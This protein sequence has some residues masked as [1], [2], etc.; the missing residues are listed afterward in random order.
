[1]T[2]MHSDS[3]LA[4]RL[5]ITHPIIQGPFGGGLS[6]VDLVAAV[7]NSGGLGSYGAHIFNGTEIKELCVRIRTK[8]DR[9]FAINLWVSN[10]DPELSKFTEPQF[11]A[12]RNHY[13]EVYQRFGLEPPEWG[14][15]H[16]ANFDE[17]MEGVLEAAPAVF[18]FVFGI[19][20][21]DILKAC[22]ERGI[23]TIAAAT[24]IAEA[25]AVEE[26]GVDMVLATGAEA[27]GHRPSF[28]RPSE[29]SLVGTFALL[30]AVRDNVRIPV[31]AAG[32]IADHRGVAAAQQLGADGVQIGTA[33]LACAESGTTSAHRESLLDNID[34]LTTLSR[35]VTRRFARFLPNELST[36]APTKG[37]SPLPFPAQSWL[38]GPIKNAAAVTVDP[39]FSS[40]YAGQVVPL[41]KHPK[42]DVLMQELIRGWN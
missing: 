30:P 15:Q 31:I 6:S 36:N 11:I 24:T 27:G 29:D 19:S 35:A 25:V 39:E 18:S 21:P 23:L 17:Q 8:T 28:L 22:R 12:Q 37:A 3:S 38:T 33:F 14:D 9:P 13:G 40:L 20:S 5:K 4:K 32:G 2:T 41:V 42:V 1:M 10:E 26:A 16:P 7:S 34:G